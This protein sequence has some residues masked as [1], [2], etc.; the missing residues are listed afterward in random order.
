MESKTI[1]RKYINIIFFLLFFL[2]IISGCATTAGSREIVVSEKEVKV[3][4]MNQNLIVKSENLKTVPSSVDNIGIN[5]YILGPGDLL[6]ITVFGVDELKGTVRISQAGFVALPLIGKINARGMT[7]D[8]LEK[9]IAKRLKEKYLEDP[10]VT[11]FIKEYNNSFVTLIGAVVKPGTQLLLSKKP[12]I[13]VLSAAGGVTKEAGGL[14]YII[15]ETHDGTNIKNNIVINLENL[16]IRGENDLNI[17]V[18]PGDMINIPIT[19]IVYVQGEVEKPGSYSLFGKMTVTNAIAVAQGVKFTASE[20]DVKI[21]RFTKDGEK[22]IIPVNYSN[23]ESG[24]EK[25]I[26][27]EPNDVIVVPRSGI[28]VAL[29]FFAR[30]IRGAFSFG[31][32]SAGF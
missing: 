7:A 4:I 31:A 10:Q 22:Q 2:Y 30:A 9:E 6:D 8:W 17:L 29:S 21:F 11:I 20:S 25:D 28:K 23:I 1:F 19:G 13:D 14:C 32:I 3:K 5:D 27:L 15:R 24:E 18:E 26:S 12:L 16:L